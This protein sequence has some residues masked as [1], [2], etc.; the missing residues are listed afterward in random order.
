MSILCS[1]NLDLVLLELKNYENRRYFTFDDQLTEDELLQ[2]FCHDYCQKLAR[3][4]D[5]NRNEVF[6]KAIYK[7][8]GQMGFLG[9]PIKGYD[10]VG[11]NYVSYGLIA[12]ESE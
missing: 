6:D 5:A 4:I 7:E 1:L 9:A 8:M 2:K 11:T 10:C 12:R 3:I